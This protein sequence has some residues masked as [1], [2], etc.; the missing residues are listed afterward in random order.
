MMRR[1][2]KVR[3]PGQGCFD[4]L[5]EPGRP[6]AAAAA[7]IRSHSKSLW[8]RLDGHATSALREAP[9]QG[10]YHEPKSTNSEIP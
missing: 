5:P 1:E 2:K 8:F 10:S 6:S 9:N 3:Q 4:T 7:T